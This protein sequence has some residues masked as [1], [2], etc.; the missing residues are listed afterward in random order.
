MA[1]N[2]L[3][4]LKKSSFD[5]AYAQRLGISSRMLSYYVKKG[6]LIR[7]THGVYAFPDKLEFDFESIVKEKL[8][9]APQAILGMHSALKLYGLTDEDRPMVELMVPEKN[10]PKKKMEDVKFYS[11]AEHL[12]NEGISKIRGIK[13]TTLE[14]TIVD[15]LKRGCTTKDARQIIEEAQ[16]KKFKFNFKEFERL[17]T[18]FHVKS[19]FTNLVG[20][21]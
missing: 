7:L 11:V 6:K 1:L 19:K 13:A 20:N 8:L 3:F 17:A 14:R 4:K 15:L 18:M 10:V 21:L 5:L 16:K 9:Q 12:F 2:L